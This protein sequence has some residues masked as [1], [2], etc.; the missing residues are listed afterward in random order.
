MRRTEPAVNRIYARPPGFTLQ[1]RA[2][3]RLRWSGAAATDYAALVVLSGDF[4][5]RPEGD[6]ESEQAKGGVIARGGALLSSPGDRLSAAARVHAEYMLVTLSPVF[7]LDCA[8]R[9]RLA[10]ADS[11]VT[12]RARSVER[13]ERL[14]RLGRDLADELEEETP[15]QELVIAAL[16]EQ[17]IVHL[18][19]R[20]TN[21][22][23]SEQLELSRAGLVDRRIRRAV[24]LM[25]A[26]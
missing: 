15:G 19:R 7:V 5:W 17:A 25:H 16:V 6:R 18:L 4:H 12:F 13:D 8:A 22:R 26:H 24:E 1:H 9:A 10:R 3:R 21:V 20:H 2:G 11:S 14:A 23:R